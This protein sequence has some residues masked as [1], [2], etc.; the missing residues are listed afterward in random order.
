MDMV[1]AKADMGIAKR[2]TEL[3]PDRALAAK[4][5]G[6]LEDEWRRTT[7]ALDTIQ[8]TTERLADNSAQHSPAR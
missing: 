2:Y 8:G 6:V 5:F 1:L 7:K 4:V 3:V